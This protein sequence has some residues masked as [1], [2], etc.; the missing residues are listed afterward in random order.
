VTHKPARRV[1]LFALVLGGVMA[2]HTVWACGPPCK[3]SSPTC[4]QKGVQCVKAPVSFY[5]WTGDCFEEGWKPHVATG[6][7][8]SYQC[9]SLQCACGPPLANEAC[10]GG[11]PCTPT[12]ANAQQAACVG[13]VVRATAEPAVKAPKKVGKVDE[14]SKVEGIK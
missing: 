13:S 1:T 9:G 6:H 12:G 2:Y 7:C 14:V 10:V 4:Y 11:T 8:G 3:V 5:V